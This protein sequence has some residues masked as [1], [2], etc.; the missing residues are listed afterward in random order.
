MIVEGVE[1]QAEFQ[2]LRDH[3]GIR[4]A[5]GYYFSRPLMLSD[6]EEGAESRAKRRTLSERYGRAR[7][8]RRVSAL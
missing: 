3:T 4:V 5:Q 6:V 8:A 1:T 7:D 2:Y